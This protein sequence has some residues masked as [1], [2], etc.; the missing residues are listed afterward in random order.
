[1]IGLAVVAFLAAI[2]MPT[3][4]ASVTAVAPYFRLRI[5]LYQLGFPTQVVIAPSNGALEI[6]DPAQRRALHPGP[7]P[8]ATVVA[9]AHGL[10]VLVGSTVLARSARP[11]VF[12]AVGRPPS[13]L[14]IRIGSSSRSR[15]PRPTTPA[16]PSGEPGGTWA[17][18]GPD[19]TPSKTL[20]AYRGSL[21]IAPWKGHL[22][23]VNVVDLEDYLKGV[24][25]A[26]MGDHAPRASFEAQAVAARTYALR[27]LKRHAA[28]GFDLCDRVHCQVYPGMLAEL[29]ASS[30]AVSRTH[31]EVLLYD[32]QF[33]NT[34][35][36]ARCGGRL[37]SSKAVWGGADVPYLPAH[38]DSLGQGGYF[39][40]LALDEIKAGVAA[41]E[42]QPPSRV[43]AI[44]QHR[45]VLRPS[46]GHRVGLCQDGAIGMG[47][48]GYS[49]AAILSFYY[50]GT[51]LALMRYATTRPPPPPALPVPGP[52]FPR[53]RPPTIKETLSQIAK[54]SPT[55]AGPA[56]PLEG[57]L[58]KWFW[59][60]MPP[61]RSSRG[62]FSPTPPLPEL[63]PAPGGTPT[64]I[65]VGEVR[66][67]SPPEAG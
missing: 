27:N 66:G 50:P 34:V 11:L 60:V 67:H 41:L 31:G 64:T 4:A 19:D 13:H 17:L 37:A 24:V 36:H 10:A 45:R 59:S 63:P 6:Y 56:V 62:A 8:E 55:G 39:C 51:R 38:D 5:G 47:L 14:L 16:S 53:A 65:Q 12:S 23:A 30:Q 26:E 61:R 42:R 54:T 52:A 21:V 7:L 28:S 3:A 44:P 9:H 57:T 18:G 48:A 35:Y 2:G 20:Y 15:K 32:G 46:R 43:A 40:N 33:A 25:P 49:K 22:F 58:Q 1:M 29:P